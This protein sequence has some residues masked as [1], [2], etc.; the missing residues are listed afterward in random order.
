M[1]R[2]SKEKSL[3]WIVGE[4]K[5]MNKYD[6][7][8]LRFNRLVG[9][10]VQP[11]G[12]YAVYNNRDQ[13][14]DWIGEGEGKIRNQLHSIFM[15]MYNFPFRSGRQSWTELF[16]SGVLFPGTDPLSVNSRGY[17]KLLRSDEQRSF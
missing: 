4:L 15:P 1:S 17:E 6:L 9:A 3:V 8:K 16:F 14:L 10:I 12:A 11:G 2:K 7:N 13:M 5:Q